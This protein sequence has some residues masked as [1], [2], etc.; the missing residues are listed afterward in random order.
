LKSKEA[1][2]PKT[3]D[4]PQPIKTSS[5]KQKIQPIETVETPV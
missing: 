1:E 5:P 2:Q 3:K 4:D